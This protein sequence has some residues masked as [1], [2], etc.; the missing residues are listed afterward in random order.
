MTALHQCSPGKLL[1]VE[2][3]KKMAANNCLLQC[4][5]VR[6]GGGGV[7]A[8]VRGKLTSHWQFFVVS[9]SQSLD[10]SPPISTF[11]HKELLWGRSAKV[12]KCCWKTS[13]MA[14]AELNW[15][16]WLQ[17]RRRREAKWAEKLPPKDDWLSRRL[18]WKLKTPRRRTQRQKLTVE[19]TWRSCE[20]S[21][22]AEQTEQNFCFKVERPAQLK[23]TFT[24]AAAAY[25][26]A[27]T[28]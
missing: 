8:V 13:A 24:T 25:L 12:Q 2:G 20:L 26:C 16:R 5:N 7:C 9:Q 27:I 4:W 6:G 10:H 14:L 23:L 11:F 3:E 19:S 1:L 22:R 21:V 15:R 18:S 17:R 28:H